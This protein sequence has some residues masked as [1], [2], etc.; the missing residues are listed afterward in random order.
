MQQARQAYGAGNIPFRTDRNIEYDAF[1]KVTA[2]LKSS[3]AARSTD[4]PAYISAIHS[5]RSLWSVIAIDVADPGNKL[6]APLR[7]QFFYLAEFTEKESRRIL[8]DKAA[9]DALVDIN[10]A[11]MRGLESKDAAQ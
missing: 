2:D 7:A 3:F 5:N 6:P 1:A 8:R 4:F 10:F 11:I 9:P